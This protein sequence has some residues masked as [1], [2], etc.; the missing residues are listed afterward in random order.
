MIG[1]K[2]FGFDDIK[3]LTEE[4]RN[5]MFR[6][7]NPNCCLIPYGIDSTTLREKD[8]ADLK[9][10]MPPHITKKFGV[11]V[12]KEKPVCSD[13]CLA[14]SSIFSIVPM[15][16][17][18]ITA[19]ASIGYSAQ[20]TACCWAGLGQFLCGIAALITC[21]VIKCVQPCVCRDKE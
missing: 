1:N 11:F 20:S 16:G 8:I 6:M 5:T 7:S 9:E 2:K 15:G 10:K 3:C 13:N 19:F 14:M 4:Q 17:G 21:G 12:I 18:G